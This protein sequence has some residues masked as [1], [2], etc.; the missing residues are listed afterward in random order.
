MCVTDEIGDHCR[1]IASAPSTLVW[2]LLNMPST[3]RKTFVRAL[4][5]LD[6]KNNNMTPFKPVVDIITFCYREYGIDYYCGFADG[7]DGW[8]RDVDALYNPGALDTIIDYWTNS[9]HYLSVQDVRKLAN[10][11]QYMYAEG[12]RLLRA[13]EDSA[14]GNTY[15]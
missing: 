7:S 11:P 12:D 2:T 10:L 4:R 13:M 6:P 9:A 3:R 5:Q 14:K 15:N 8:L 1:V